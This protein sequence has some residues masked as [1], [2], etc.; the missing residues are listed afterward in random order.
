MT[1]GR[2]GHA[3]T[4]T[5]RISSAG[6]R[7]RMTVGSVSSVSTVSAAYA[8]DPTMKQRQLARFDNNGQAC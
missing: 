8:E 1:F 3:G 2:E 6:E 4:R 7:R 5:I